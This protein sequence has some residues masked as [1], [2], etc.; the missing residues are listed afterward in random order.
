MKRKTIFGA[1]IQGEVCR[2]LGEKK[3]DWDRLTVHVLHKRVILV[4]R[5]YTKTLTGKARV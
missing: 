1:F 5:K 3:R 2:S 4:R